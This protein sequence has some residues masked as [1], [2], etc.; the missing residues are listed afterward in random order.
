VEGAE[1]VF[2]SVGFNFEVIGDRVAFR[3]VQRIISFSGCSSWKHCS[4]GYGL[5]LSSLGGVCLAVLGGL[6]E[7]ALS[8]CC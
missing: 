7:F 3:P 1:A 8:I 4:M 2:G 6:P 5:A